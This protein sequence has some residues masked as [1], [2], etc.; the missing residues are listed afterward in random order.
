MQDL[1][2][3]AALYVR[4]SAD[5]SKTQL[6]V[7]R[8]EADLRREAKRRGVQVVLLLEDNDLSASGK[9]YRPDFERLLEG[10]Q[11]GEI[12]LVM[13]YDLDRLNRGMHDY[14][15]FYDACEKAKVTVAWI[16]GEANFANRDGHL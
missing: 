10:I 3:L 12:G 15:R 7:R 9:D 14:V 4:I 5:P 2:K 8:Q 1:S 6:G 16:G 13:A 11:R